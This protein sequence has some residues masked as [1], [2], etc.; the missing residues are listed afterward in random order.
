MRVLLVLLVACGGKDEASDSSA[1]CDPSVTYESF[2]RGFVT[3]H[4]QTCHAS[5]SPDRRGAPRDVVFDTEDDV[6]ANADAIRVRAIEQGDMP[7]QGGV[8]ADDLALLDRWLSCG[9]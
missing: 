8:S 7:P 1:P 5:T 4:C 6:W 2:G 3:Q 9:G